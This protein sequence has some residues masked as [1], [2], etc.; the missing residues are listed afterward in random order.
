MRLSTLALFLTSLLLHVVVHAA[1]LQRL[2]DKIVRIVDGDTLVLEAEG[3][4]HRVRLAGIDAPERNQPWGQASTR[5]LRRQVAGEPI[6]VDWYKRDRWERVIGI[7][8]LNGED[9]NL[10]LVDRGLTW[11][12]MRYADEQMQQDRDAYAKA[13]KT[14]RAARRGLWSD[15]EPVPPWEWRKR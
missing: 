11:H 6:V 12:Y 10:H 13:E 7:V 8:R 5:E 15:P 1:D 14:V 2:P 3:I 9:V 4:R